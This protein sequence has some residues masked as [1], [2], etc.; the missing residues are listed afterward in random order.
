MKIGNQ[1]PATIINGDTDR[2]CYN[3]RPYL[4]NAKFSDKDYDEK[5][6]KNPNHYLKTLYAS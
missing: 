1:L 2:P 5:R 6:K 3:F 4:E